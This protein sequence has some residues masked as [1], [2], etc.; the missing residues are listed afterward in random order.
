MTTE[1]IV[2]AAKQDDLPALCSLLQHLFSQEAE[3]T[4]NRDLQAQGLSAI[5]ADP[6][7]GLILVARADDQVIGMVVLLYTISTSLGGRVALL[8]DM[9]VAPDQRGRGVG[10]KLIKQAIANAERDGCRR[11]TLLTDADNELAQQFYR[12]NGFEASAMRA[13]R[14]YIPAR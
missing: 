12:R 7:A 11:I 5:L 8:E 4:P 2:N 1:T 14:R 6:N 13:L 10:T 9:I 3:F